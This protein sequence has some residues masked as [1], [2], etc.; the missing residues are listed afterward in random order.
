VNR[1]GRLSTVLSFCALAA[2]CDVCGQS[3]PSVGEAWQSS[4][5]EGTQVWPVE[6]GSSPQAGFALPVYRHWPERPFQ[7]V[8]LIHPSGQHGSWNAADISTAVEMAKMQ[9]AD[10]L[11]LCGARDLQA[12]KSADADPQVIPPGETG[13]FAIRWIPPREASDAAHRLDG[14]RAYLRRSYP[15]LHLEAK[16]DLWKIGLEAM[17]WLG[18]DVDAERGA[19][20][21]EETLAGL[22]APP[23]AP[24][25]RWL[26]KG[27]AR[28]T[29]A[30]SPPPRFVYG[31]AVLTCEGDHASL[32]CKANGLLVQFD[33]VADNGKLSG[34]LKWSDRGFS[35]EQRVQ[36]SLDEE[37]IRL[38]TAGAPVEGAPRAE[39]IFL[40]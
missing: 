38:E 7:I 39:F 27:V 4:P 17:A 20:R 16:S 5:Y 30:D 40:H 26:C 24:S 2:V 13:A 12:V 28:S 34:Q 37:A 29:A 19:G 9:S 18:V 22:V 11:L 36:G 8:S 6:K 10:A 21:F 3:H 1:L 25:T 32:V 31:V 33:G 15:P 23:G 14:F 35:L